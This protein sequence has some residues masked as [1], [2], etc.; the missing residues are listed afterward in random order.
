[1]LWLMFLCL[2]MV[3]SEQQWHLLHWLKLVW[4]RILS[5]VVSLHCCHQ[6]PLQNC[7]YSQKL[8]SYSPGL[9][10]LKDVF[11]QL[12]KNT[13]SL[14][15]TPPL[16][17]CNSGDRLN[18]YRKSDLCKQEGFCLNCNSCLIPS[19]AWEIK[20]EINTL[21]EL[22]CFT[23]FSIK[24][25]SLQIDPKFKEKYHPRGNWPPVSRGPQGL[26]FH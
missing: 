13:L 6:E 16:G 22:K 10:Q 18:L 2:I 24:D 23:C 12:V 21:S 5:K 9:N 3:L 26:C 17:R 25:C 7:H 4:N 1:M 11:I 15:N 20:V 8:N 19:L 14:K